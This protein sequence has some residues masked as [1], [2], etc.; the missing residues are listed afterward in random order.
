MTRVLVVGCDA[1]WRKTL[2]WMLSEA[3]YAV[4][5]IAD[6]DFALKGL[7]V[8][9]SPLVVIITHGGAGSEGLKILEQ[10]PTLPP[11]EYI[12]L[13][14]VPQRAPWVWNPSFWHF[15][16]VVP[17]PF[18]LDLLLDRVAEAARRIACL[19]PAEPPECAV[20]GEPV[21]ALRLIEST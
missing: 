8:S 9:F 10:S 14:A 13:S 16:P 5:G 4:A 3:G 7:R 21:P 12:L 15:V 20:S 2:E 19:A 11:H 18:D 6:T 1:R 17:A